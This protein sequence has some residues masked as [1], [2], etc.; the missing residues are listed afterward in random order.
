MTEKEIFRKVSLERLSS[1]EQ[2]D[3]TIQIVSPKGWITLLGV[4]CLLL[5]V[6]LWGFFGSISTQVNGQGIIMSEKGAF[7]IVVRSE[8]IIAKLYV[9][10]G[11]K[12][13]PGQLVASIFQ[14][15]LA[16]DLLTSQSTL[17]D[18]KI[19]FENTMG[20]YNKDTKLYQEEKITDLQYYNMQDKLSSLTLQLDEWEGKI[21]SLQDQLEDTSEIKSP[22]SGIVFELD[23]LE[24]E[25][26]E[27]GDSIVKLELSGSKLQAF[28]YFPPADGKK[29]V[30][31]MKSHLSPTTVKEEEYGFIRGEVKQ[32]SLFPMSKAGVM[33]ILQ[34][35]SLT[36]EIMKLESPIEVRVNL[37]TD[38]STLSG[39]QWSFKGGPPIKIYS[40]TLC[41]GSVVISSQPPVNL[42][43]PLLKKHVLG[44]GRE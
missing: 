15:E 25:L 17:K 42:V 8:G 35:E 16:D 2:L 41:N 3:Q 31:G 38:S 10:I 19:E 9:D 1:P 11:E 7:Q 30:E 23:V 13:E 33:R 43:I 22:Y 26:V 18:L 6:C 20:E 40:G 14:P 12:V 4:G 32:V 24:G 28:L 34:N 5:V 37:F 36:E 21:R 27:K 44:I 29:I 39:Y